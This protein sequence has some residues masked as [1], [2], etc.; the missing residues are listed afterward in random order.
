V[1]KVVETDG[2]GETRLVEEGLER[3]AEEVVAVEGRAEGRCEDEAVVLPE[4]V[5]LLSLF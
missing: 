3:A 5:E 2:V 1:P 4:P